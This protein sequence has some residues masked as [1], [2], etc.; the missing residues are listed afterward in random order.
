MLAGIACRESLALDPDGPMDRSPCSP[1]IY[2]LRSLSPLSQ[3]NAPLCLFLN[4]HPSS[5]ISAIAVYALHKI[6]YQSELGAWAVAEAH[7]LPPLAELLKASNSSGILIRICQIFAIV[8][9]YR[10]AVVDAE[11]TWALAELL[12]SIPEIS[13]A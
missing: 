7:A 9:S 8:A 11:G 2:L 3:F 12:R 1:L 10:S 4:S 5:T 13:S 6:G